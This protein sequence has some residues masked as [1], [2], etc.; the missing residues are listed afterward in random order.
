MARKN[1]KHIK[2]NRGL[3]HTEYE[4]SLPIGVRHITVPVNTEVRQMD[5]PEK[6][7]IWWVIFP[8]NLEDESVVT[9]MDARIFGVQV[10]SNLVYDTGAGDVR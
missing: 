6:K 3:T 8:E 4:A 9:R 10:P 5:A 7:K 2:Y 1:R